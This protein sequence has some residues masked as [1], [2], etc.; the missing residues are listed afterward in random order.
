[1]ARRVLQQLA[2]HAARRLYSSSAEVACKPPASAASAAASAA[3]ST[4]ST[5]GGT[6]AEAAAAVAA[7][8]AAGSGTAAANAAARAL[9][10][11]FADVAARQRAFM[12]E[13]M[14]ARAPRSER[15]LGAGAAAR[16]LRELEG[17]LRAALPRL[18]ARD[19]GAA[20]AAWGHARH[21]Y[22]PPAELVRAVAA[23]LLRQLQAGDA[24]PEPAV[25]AEKGGGGEERSEPQPAAAARYVV[26][27]L[28]GAAAAAD[29]AG[30]RAS[31]DNAAAGNLP[32]LRTWREAFVPFAP[33]RVFS[34]S[35]AASRSSGG[36]S[37][38]RRRP[39]E[40]LSAAAAAAA[41]EQFGGVGDGAAAA[42]A[43]AGADERLRCA[44][45]ALLHLSFVAAAAPGLEAPVA[46][47][48]A[49][50][51]PALLALL[52]RQ[53]GSGSA[54]S[55]E[56]RQEGG[57]ANQAALASAVIALRAASRLP[58]GAARDALLAPL[59][60]LLAPRVECLDVRLAIGAVEALAEVEA[61]SRTGEFDSSGSGG[62]SSSSNSSVGGVLS[63]AALPLGADGQPE[64][65][66]GWAA[67]A[68][69]GGGG[70]GA[71]AVL[72][73]RELAALRDA[74]RAALE[75]LD[76][77]CARLAALAPVMSP[78]DVAAASAALSWL[79]GA[80]QRFAYAPG[81]SAVSLTLRPLAAMA[82]AIVQRPREQ[83]VPLR[84][85]PHIAG[86]Y[87]RL[88]YGDAALFARLA[89]DVLADAAGGNGGGGV[90]AL[91][92]AQLAALMWAFAAVGVR[93]DAL[94][95][96]CCA[97]AA[98]RAH[99]MSREQLCGAL[100]AAAALGAD[101]APLLRAGARA[102]AGWGAD[103]MRRL[104]ETAASQLLYVH[105]LHSLLADPAAAK[106][107]LTAALSAAGFQQQQGA[108]GA[109]AA[110]ALAAGA[111]QHDPPPLRARP[112]LFAL[113]PAAAAA[114][115]RRVAR[116]RRGAVAVTAFQ[117]GVAACLA[118]E[119]RLPVASEVPL[120]GAYSIDALALLRLSPVSGGAVANGGG[121]VG[122]AETTAVAVET[123][124][125]WHFTRDASRRANGKTR[126]RDRL[127]RAV[128]LRVAAV[129]LHEWAKLRGRRERAE[130]VRRLLDGAAVAA[131]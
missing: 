101:D 31:E 44:G 17:P 42:A 83:R 119:L 111:Q 90:A 80:P 21:A 8:G 29:A 22:A 61:G 87:A 19:A 57:D 71:S 30:P 15:R 6:A 51:A 96:A 24:E 117:R 122:A 63:T 102:A 41:D 88:V 58:V 45:Y 36:G 20:L 110:P 131:G 72:P 116:A 26:A 9:G 28:S 48:A 34:S 109:Q 70:S 33:D 1:M 93:H 130:Y 94:L 95:A 98:A 37:A 77:A 27:P 85:A 43:A 62:S 10:E 89:D 100:W 107:A 67:R 55:S 12:R 105:D 84:T 7:L 66:D 123:D 32:P 126:L 23:Q 91:P 18:R 128:G 11:A 108:A 54:G 82:R 86:A 5:G 53:L 120:L 65:D 73:R 2:A 14:V 74:Q 39:W 121:S 59:L 78:E 129:P 4:H 68:V 92:P 49:A 97:A 113:P 35:D 99:A 127:L 75:V 81:V 56:Q 112:P 125:P 104:P 79:C 3:A 118:R 60:R 40:A 38:A 13:V 103:A 76:A 115:R 46:E 106:S 16:E 114:L 50:L 64:L 124:G 25:A 52:R 47:A 69:R